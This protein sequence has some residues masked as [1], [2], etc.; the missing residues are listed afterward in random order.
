MTLCHNK[1][2]KM[3][4]AL[5]EEVCHDVAIEPIL[6]SVTNNNLVP[7]ANTNNGA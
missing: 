3:T 4:N 6:Q 5:F 2:S 1:I 7:S